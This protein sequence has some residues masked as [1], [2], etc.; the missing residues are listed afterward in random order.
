[1]DIVAKTARVGQGVRGRPMLA[2]GHS[3][4]QTFRVLSYCKL[5]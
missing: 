3:L 2:F 4:A 1:M 5:L